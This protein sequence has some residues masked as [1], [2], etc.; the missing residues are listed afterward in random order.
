VPKRT[1]RHRIH[2]INPT[3]VDNA[4]PPNVVISDIRMPGS[5]GLSLLKQLK[6]VHPDLPI[7]IMTAYSDLDSTVAAFEEGAFE[8]I[9]K[10]FAAKYKNQHQ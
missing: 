2:G 10:P 7:L 6:A 9:A 1:G 3:G 5:D 8:Y 4:I